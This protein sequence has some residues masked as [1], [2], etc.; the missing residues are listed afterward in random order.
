MREGHRQ[1]EKVLGEMKGIVARATAA[2]AAE[3]PAGGEH[4]D[5]PPAVQRAPDAEMADAL[6]AAVERLRARAQAAPPSPDPGPRDA[7]R[8]QV[9]A[10]VQRVP[11]KHSLSLIGRLR[12]RRKQRRTR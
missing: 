7:E 11:H 1:M 5:S 8:A 4:E 12:N 6:A 9:A 2:L 3:L 10:V